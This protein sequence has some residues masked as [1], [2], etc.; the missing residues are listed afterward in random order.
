[1][2]GFGAESEMARSMDELYPQK[3]LEFLNQNP[4]QDPLLFKV[5][6][7]IFR[8]CQKEKERIKQKEIAQNI[9]IIVCCLFFSLMIAL[10]VAQNFEDAALI[11]R[12]S[13]IMNMTFYES[14]KNKSAVP[15]LSS[16][17]GFSSLFEK[18]HAN[19]ISPYITNTNS[20]T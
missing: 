4:A 17:S 12:A 2:T 3:E 15:K 18:L 10:V 7:L 1:M 9:T 20:T 8:Q 16:T 13:S 11:S 6:E 19:I 14:L 5:S